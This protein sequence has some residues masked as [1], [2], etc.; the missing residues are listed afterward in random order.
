MTPELKERDP[1]NRL[2]RAAIFL[3]AAGELIRDNA[4]AASGLLVRELGG[5]GAHPYQPAGFTS[6][7]TSRSAITKP[8][9]TPASFAAA[10]NTHWQRQYVH[11]CSRRSTRRRARSARCNGRPATLRWRPG[12]VER[13]VVC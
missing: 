6:I 7:S 1:Q 12:A 5:A 2:F 4:L 9:K 8:M 11:P 10:S 3:S 13:P